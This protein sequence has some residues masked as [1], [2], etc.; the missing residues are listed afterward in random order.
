MHSKLQLPSGLVKDGPPGGPTWT[1]NTGAALTVC[2]L[3]GE[4]ER[5]VTLA[6]AAIDR[7]KGLYDLSVV[8]PD[9]RFWWDQTYFVQLLIEGLVTFIETFGS[10]HEKLADA[11]AAEVEREMG[12][13]LSELRDRDGLT[14]R[15]WRLYRIGEVQEERFREVCGEAPGR[16]EGWDESERWIMKGVEVGRRKLCKTLLGSA[17]SARALC[18]AGRLG[19]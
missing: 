3:L 15:N 19:V 11:A 1:Y 14:W 6:A 7:S 16:Q 12:Y 4:E 13:L 8:D 17:G 10:S 2:C 9:R 18:I 5:A